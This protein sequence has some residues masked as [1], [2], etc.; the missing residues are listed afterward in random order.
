MTNFA[1]LSRGIAGP[2]HGDIA[3]PGE[4]IAEGVCALTIHLQKR[5][6]R[7]CR[8]EMLVTVLITPLA[9]PPVFRSPLNGPWQDL[10][11]HHTSARVPDSRP[12]P[13]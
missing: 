4:D 6:V 1:I 10:P 13:D 9:S 11:V 3:F 7:G 8:A 12:S 2:A 5:T